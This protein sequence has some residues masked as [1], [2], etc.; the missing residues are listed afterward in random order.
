VNSL[1]AKMAAAG[2]VGL[3]GVGLAMPAASASAPR[4]VGSHGSCSATSTWTMKAKADSGKIDVEF[5]VDS[6]RA[7]QTWM[8]NLLDNG[9]RVFH[10]TR[11][12]DG[13]SGS[14]DVSK[15]IA[16]RSGIDHLIGTARRPA[17]GEVCRASLNF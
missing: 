15:L 13:P 16:N 8:V 7:G 5:Q 2:V 17:T 12:T 14:F 3:V 11:L 9:V 1:T 6:N 4:I 10:G